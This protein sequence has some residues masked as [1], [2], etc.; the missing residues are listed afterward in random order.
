MIDL[1]NQ[2]N[3]GEITLS[4]LADLAHEKTNVKLISHDQNRAVFQLYNGN[5]LIVEK[6]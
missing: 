5:R 3:N 2:F 6:K 1:I 4:Q